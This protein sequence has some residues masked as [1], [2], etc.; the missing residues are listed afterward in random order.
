[1][2]HVLRIASFGHTSGSPYGAR[3]QLASQQRVNKAMCGIALIRVY[4]RTCTMSSIMVTCTMSLDCE[5][6]IKK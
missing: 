2:H 3:A 4:I 5:M 1:M 6:R